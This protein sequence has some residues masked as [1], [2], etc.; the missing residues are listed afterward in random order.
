MKNSFERNWIGDGAGSVFNLR[1]MELL[2]D[3]FAKQVQQTNN[4]PVPGCAHTP[5]SLMDYIRRVNRLAC[6]TVRYHFHLLTNT[7]ATTGTTTKIMHTADRTPLQV[8]F[9]EYRGPRP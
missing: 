8:F 6:L 3:W 2:M 7:T 5:D 4:V 9:L 1:L